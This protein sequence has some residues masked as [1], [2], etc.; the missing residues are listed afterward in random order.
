MYRQYFYNTSLIY[1]KAEEKYHFIHDGDTIQ[2]NK[3]GCKPSKVEGVQPTYDELQ[4]L[5]LRLH[6]KVRAQCTSF[7][8]LELNRTLCKKAKAYATKVAMSGLYDHLWNGDSTIGQD[9]NIYH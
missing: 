9:K 4:L 3:D 5:V 8:P 2:Y 6:N 7:Q 1:S